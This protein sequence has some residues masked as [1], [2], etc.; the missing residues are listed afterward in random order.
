MKIVHRIIIKINRCLEPVPSPTRDSYG[1]NPCVV[2]IVLQLIKGISQGK[3]VLVLI[4]GS[5][6]DHFI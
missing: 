1:W 4:L 2:S 6:L 3:G 5:D